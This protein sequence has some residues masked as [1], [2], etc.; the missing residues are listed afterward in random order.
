MTDDNEL[1]PVA[2]LRAAD[3][4]ADLEAPAG[5]A[6][7]VVA[8]AT[9]TATEQDAPVADISS[10]RARRRRVW[11]PIAAV[12]ASVVVFGG[13]GFAVGSVTT[14]S[15][16]A[17]GAAAPITLEGG[18]GAQTAEGRSAV[19]GPAA[20]Q[21][22]AAPGAFDQVYRSGFG[23]NSFTASGLSTSTGTARAYG[24]DAR[25][26][27]DAKTVGALA[28]ALGIE[29][30][31]ALKDGSWQAGP[32]DG[33][34]PSLT[35]GLDGTLSFYYTNPK[36]SPMP[37]LTTDSGSGSGSGSDGS[38]DGGVAPAEPCTAP[39][40][41]SLPAP[42]AAIAAL[43]SLITASGRDAGA[44]EF[45]SETPEGAITRTAQAWPVVEGQR[46]DQ[47][48]SVEL[49]AEGV[50]SASGPLA[51]IVELDDYPVVSEQQAFERLSDPRFGAQQTAMPLALRTAEQSTAP[52]PRDTPTQPPALPG[53][54]ASPSWPVNDV[55]IVSARLGLASQWQPDG[56]VL[57]LP[58]YELTDSDGGTW[59]VI[60]VADAKLDFAVG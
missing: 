4:A 43:R 16:V 54:G 11:L 18:G 29:A 31:P 7:R 25:A 9:G 13:A 40:S 50:V 57:V 58:A 37:C 33:T 2:R 22:I 28:K 24:F 53:S 46:V 51:P 6:A 23:R 15:N 8:E 35:V 44:F 47:P 17:G 5:F 41:P 14:A 52:T 36:L 59:S 1:D 48:W 27:S 26:A 3:P 56:S 39:A 38:T 32:Q 30:A 10:A 60:A 42:D 19:A 12:A 20:G 45:T 21:K 49:T 34:A 55:H